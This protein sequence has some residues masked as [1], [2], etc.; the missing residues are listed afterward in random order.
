MVPESS[1]TGFFNV[2]ISSLHSKSLHSQHNAIMDLNLNKHQNLSDA[3]MLIWTKTC[4]ECFQD[5]AEP[6]PQR[7]KVGTTKWPVSVYIGH[8]NE[9]FLLFTI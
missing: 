3:I 9:I 6:I 2:T 5:L 8:F 4:K 7:I 1:E